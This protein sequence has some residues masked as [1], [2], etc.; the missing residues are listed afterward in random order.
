MRTRI[1]AAILAAG[2][3]ASGGAAMYFD[4]A[5]GAHPA[6][7]HHAAMYYTSKPGMYYTSKPSMYYT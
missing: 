7:V 4:A 3:L 6:T 5:P 2:T 1:A